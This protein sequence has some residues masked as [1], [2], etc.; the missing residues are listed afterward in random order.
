MYIT[1]VAFKGIYDIS[2]IIYGRVISKNYLWD[3]KNNY[4]VYSSQTENN[5]KLDKI[6]NYDFDG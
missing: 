3:N 2:L 4:L 5:E 6:L 1:E